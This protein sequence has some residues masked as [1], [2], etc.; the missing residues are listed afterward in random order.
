MC[1]LSYWRALNTG[2]NAWPQAGEADTIPSPRDR[3]PAEQPH[4]NARRHGNNSSNTAITALTA[5]ISF[6]FRPDRLANLRRVVD[7]ISGYSGF[8]RKDVWVHTNEWFDRLPPIAKVVVHDMSDFHRKQLAWLHRPLLK[9][10]VGAYDVY[11]YLE[12]DILV[13]QEALDYWL[14]YEPR[15]SPLGYDLG[16]LRIERDDQGTEYVVDFHAGESCSEV[17]PVHGA[18]YVRLR[19]NYRGF[20]IYTKDQLHE[21]AQRE[22]FCSVPS[23]RRTMEKAARGM[24]TRETETLVPLE[25]GEM[26][27]RCRVYHLAN[28][29][30]ADPE[31]MHAK[32][33]YE[34]LLDLDGGSREWHCTGRAGIVSDAKPHIVRH[35]SAEDTVAAKVASAF[36]FALTDPVADEHTYLDLDGMS[37]RR[38][39]RFVN[40]LARS[41]DDARY[42]E[43]GVWAG[44]TLCSAIA[45]NN[46]VAVG[47]DNWSKFGG[48]RERPQENVA[49]FARDSA[50]ATILEADFHAVDFATLGRFN[51]YLYDGPH[52]ERDQYEGLTVALPALDDEFVLIVDDWNWPQVREGTARAIAEFDLD[53]LFAIEV[54]T[55]LDGNHPPHSGSDAKLTDWHNGYF[56]AVLRQ[57]RGT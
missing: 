12:D 19:H 43:V 20:W 49:A 56:L 16:F 27:A 48:P 32:I 11:M 2:A 53:Q 42:L 3:S 24:Q 36:E 51:V 7:A 57:P 26:D 34:D 33:R 15:L 14:E 41:L 13:P 52:E 55:T 6:Y 8:E 9:S 18:E 40:E 23:K 54:R 35:G 31:S 1:L 28:N 46:V 10:Q 44:S 45:G 5:H 21:F 30:W 50:S 38:Y 4:L 25:C 37:G 47:I 29:Y 22:G 17:E 39:R